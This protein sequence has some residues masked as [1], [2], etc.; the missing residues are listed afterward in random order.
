MK[1][2]NYKITLNNL[3]LR[4]FAR[5]LDYLFFYVGIA[6]GI[7]ISPFIVPDVL[8]L[9]AALFIPLFFLPFE[10][11]YLKL[12]GTTPGKALLGIHLRTKNKEKP[13]WKQAFKRSFEVA[14]RGTGFGIPFINVICMYFYFKKLRKKEPQ[15]L[16]VYISSKRIFKTC[17]ASLLFILVALPAGIPSI[18]DRFFDTGTPL[19]SD[20]LRQ[21]EFHLAE[22]LRWKKFTAPQGDFTINF[23]KLPKEESRKLPI[24]NSKNTLPYTEF[25]CTHTSG[26]NYSISYTILPSKW[27]KYSSSLVLKGSL[28]FINK[29]I[30]KSEIVSK[31]VHRFKS[32]PALDYTLFNGEVEQRGKLILIGNTLYK[33]EVTYRPSQK[34]SVEKTLNAFL[35]SFESAK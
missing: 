30:G 35:N 26:T 34:E 8:Y 3:Y 4:A 31:R 13:S 12:F 24:P 2:E 14:A 5:A 21:G 1:Y 18:Q 17:F 32:L 29:H 7:F 27:L 20:M 10:T 22:N 6:L 11:L 16:D 25:Q 23:P 15:E 28:R 19:F 9:I 33:I